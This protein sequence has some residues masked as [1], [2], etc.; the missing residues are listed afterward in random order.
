MA[1]NV[2][3]HLLRA[4]G[5]DVTEAVIVVLGVL[6]TEGGEGIQKVAGEQA[7]ADAYLQHKDLIL[8]RPILGSGLQVRDED[9][10]GPAR[11]GAVIVNDERDR[12]AIGNECL[13][14]SLP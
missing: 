7:H 10:S 12:A 4:I 3:E 14:A 11:A 6:P 13:V 9:L 8:Q 1:A 5:G 2:A